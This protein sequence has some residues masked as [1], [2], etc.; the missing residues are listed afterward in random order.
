[1][2]FDLDAKL[3]DDILHA[4]DAGFADQ[5]K[6]TQ[7]LVRLPSLRGQE[8]TAQD[9]LFQQMAS[10]GLTMD[11]WAIDVDAIKHHPGFSP[12]AVDYSNAFNVVGAHRPK[13]QK[14]KSLILN[15]HVDVVPLGPLDMW[16]RP[17]FDPVI[18]GDWLHGRGS[19]DMKAGLIANIAALD[20]LRRLGYQPAAPVYVQSVT[21]EECT[22]NG[23][24]ACLLRGYRAEAAIIPE[25]GDDCLTRA[26]MGVIWFRV[27]V[28]GLPVHTSHAGSGVNAIEASYKLIQA[29]HGLEAEWNARRVN[30]RHFEELPHPVNLNIGKIAGGDWASSVP[31]WCS[32]DCRISFYPGISARQAADEIEACIGKAVRQDSFLSNMPPKIEYNGFFAEGYVL[33][34]GTEAERVLADAHQRS[35]GSKL[36]ARVAQAYVDGRV[37]MLYDDC[38]A[39]VYGPKSKNYHGFDEC[40][41]LSSTKRVT[42]AIALFIAEWCKLERT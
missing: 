10:R 42:A 11:R 28:R 5:V 30:H 32:F 34:E 4:V 8:H 15:G 36:E 23:A 29:L 25:P 21:E 37:F 9:F 38:P 13:D 22:G 12:V 2:P 40:V 31:A 20:A 17:P 27:H 19:G 35:Y 6:L 41:S 33:N 39:L 14:G 7:D 16:E 24:L 3:Q 1:M 18:E 26:N